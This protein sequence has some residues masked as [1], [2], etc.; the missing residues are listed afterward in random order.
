MLRSSSLYSIFFLLAW[1]SL[2]TPTAVFAADDS[3][4]DFL[5]DDFYEIDSAGSVV[6]DPLEP[7]NRVVFQINDTLYIWVMEPVATLYSNVLPS[8][9]RGCIYNFFHNLEEPVRFVNT[10]L[11]ARFAD[12]GD[13]LLRFMINSTLGVYGFGDAAARVFDIPPVDATLG[14]TLA[15]WG[16]GDVCYLVIPLFGPSTLR[17]FT[18]KV[19]DG[20]GMT[21]YYAWTDDVYVMGGVY[22]GR[23]TN[24]LSMHLGEYEELKKVLFD[25]YISFR[26]AYYQHRRKIW[27]HSPNE[28]MGTDE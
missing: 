12:A 20:F 19:V 21:P 13:V 11:Q 14:E 8:D 24:T 25:P 7:V 22:V 9:V 26:N 23:E 16:I 1:Y 27:A 3:A 28:G 6:E 15:G 4:A 10:L 5:S 2:S 18:G 17:D